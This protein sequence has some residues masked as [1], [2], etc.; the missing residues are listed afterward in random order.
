[1]EMLMKNK[2][3]VLLTL[4]AAAI[5]CGCFALDAKSSDLQVSALKLRVVDF[6]KAVE[7]S[8]HG[9]EEQ[10]HF[11]A[12]KKQMESV[13]EEKDKALNEIAA[14]L[15][16]P[17]YMDGLSHEAEKE[18]R[19]KYRVGGQ[20]LSQIESQYYQALSQAN[21]KILQN[22]NTLVSDAVKQVAKNQKIDVVLREDSAF[23]SDDALDITADV[24][25]ALD[26]AFSK[27]A[28]EKK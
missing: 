18:L 1:M 11:E 15:E 10:T 3:A 6:K 19:H 2:F 17:D 22:L 13:L 26:E 8:K 14:K 28:T 27:Q 16:D 9:K 24:I 20:E 21:T 25:T 23:Y 5:S 12:L 7:S 4:A